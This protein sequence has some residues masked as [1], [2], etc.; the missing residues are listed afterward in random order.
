MPKKKANTITEFSSDKEQV[1]LE[2]IPNNPQKIEG[3]VPNSKTDNDIDKK[4]SEI[5]YKIVRE[6]YRHYG[7]K[8]SHTN[9][10]LYQGVMFEVARLSNKTIEEV[11]QKWPK[12]DIFSISEGVKKV[13]REELENDQNIMYRMIM[14][15]RIIADRVLAKMIAKNLTQ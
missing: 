5:S 6:L 2:Q 15:D 1:K 11:T 7:T 14:N 3:T 10:H 9:K 13:V 8:D 12:F 4:V